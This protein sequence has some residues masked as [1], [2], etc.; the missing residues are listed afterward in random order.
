MIEDSGVSSVNEAFGVD[1]NPFG[2]GQADGVDV[3]CQTG[4]RLQLNQGNVRFGY[5]ERTCNS[6]DLE[7]E[8]VTKHLQKNL[9]N[10]I[11]LELASNSPERKFNVVL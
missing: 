7:K 4:L 11:N 9:S 8:K 3:L 1:G 10:R 6:N 2:V 5:D